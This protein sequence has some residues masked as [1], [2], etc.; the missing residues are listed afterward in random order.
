MK[1]TKITNLEK[2][3]LR[4]WFTLVELI[5]VITILAILATI[6]FISFQWYT[7]SARDWNRLATVT[8]ISKWIDIYWIQVW[9]FPEPD[10]TILSWSLAWVQLNRLWIIW[11]NISRLIKLN[12]TPTDPV[13]WNNY[14]YAVSPDNKYYQIWMTLENLESYNNI[15]KTT[16]ADNWSFK[17]KVLWNYKYPLK[18]WTKLYSL[19]SLIF[20]WTWWDLSQTWNAYFIVDKWLNIPYTPDKSALNN[21]QTTTQVLQSITWT[22]WVTL[23]WITLPTETS[24]QFKT[25]TSTSTTIQ[26]LQQALWIT[27]QTQLW[28]VI[29]WSNYNTNTSLNATSWWWSSPTWTFAL[30]STS[31]TSWTPVTITNNCTTSPTSYTSSNT[32]VATIAWTTITTLTAWTTNITPVWWSC[33]DSSAKTL[34]VT[35]PANS[36]N[37]TQPT[38]ATLTTWTPTNSN[39]AWQ[40]NDSSQP[41]HFVCNA[42]YWY[43]WT[44]C[45]SAT[46]CASWL[47]YITLSNWQSWSCKNFW[48]TTVWD[49]STQP[50]D[51]WWGA[52]NCNSSLTW[53]WDYYQWWR[54]DTWWTNWQAWWNYD[55]QT[56]QVDT[57]WWWS[58]SDTAT[59]DW[60]WTTKVW[61]KWPCS[62]WW[63]VPSTKD[64]QDMCNSVL[65][66]TCSNAMWY[67]SL[68]ATKLRLPFAGYRNRSTGYYNGQSSGS[69]YWSSSP[70]TTDSYHL[71]FN[72]SNIRPTSSNSRA[73]GFSVRCIKN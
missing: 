26:N 1:K 58:S 47:S 52:S 61:R 28:T 35:A 55:W 5:I 10:G 51:C 18:I 45:V 70:Y 54:N 57:A 48:A 9:T 23:T 34:T 72:T 37:T 13:W 60:A 63:H 53:L 17:A 67:N 24:E 71:A 49:W 16:Y 31:V 8:N 6:A 68:I 41:C 3:K 11:D 29:Y 30:S 12:K 43:D 44:N 42:W 36:C 73:T 2:T 19:P 27:D 64:W 20:T 65:W 66:T 69:Y 22:W 50:T 4:K 39:Q 7:K 38:N 59:S 21:T 40:T 32:S 14:V 15:T 33:S 56:P 25:L 46:N 62:T